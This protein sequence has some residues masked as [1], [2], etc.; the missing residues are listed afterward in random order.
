MFRSDYILGCNE[1]QREFIKLQWWNAHASKKRYYF[2]VTAYQTW[3]GRVRY[4]APV[5]CMPGPTALYRVRVYP[6]VV[7]ND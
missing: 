5:Y 4:T 3:R 7:R 2:T 6:K 1:S